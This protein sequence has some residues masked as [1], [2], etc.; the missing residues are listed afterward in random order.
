MANT[1]LPSHRDLGVEIGPHLNGLAEEASEL[2][3]AI[4][5]KPRKNAIA[6]CDH[7]M[8]TMDEVY[9]LL[10]MI[11]FPNSITSGLSRSTEFSCGRLA[12]CLR[13]L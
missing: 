1:S 4:L 8:S 2:R 13:C 7:L 5:D 6:P 9:H 11:A 3:R 12:C 10:V